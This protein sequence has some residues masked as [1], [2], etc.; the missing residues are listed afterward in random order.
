[1]IKNVYWCSC[2]VAFIIVKILMKFEFSRQILEKNILRYQISWKFVHWE[3][4][5]SMRTD[6]Q[7]CGGQ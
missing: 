5:C 7:T 3:P 6:G 1:M 2:K 4:S